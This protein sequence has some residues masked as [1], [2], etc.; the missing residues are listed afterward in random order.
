MDHRINMV[1]AKVK[2]IKCAFSA[3]WPLTS[4][5]LCHFVKAYIYVC[6]NECPKWPIK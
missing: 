3:I 2:E 1:N 4:E 5:C 6:L